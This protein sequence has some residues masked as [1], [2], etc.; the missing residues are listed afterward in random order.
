LELAVH[1]R[2]FTQREMTMCGSHPSL[3]SLLEYMCG[4]FGKDEK[5]L[6]DCS[7]LRWKSSTPPLL[8]AGLPSGNAYSS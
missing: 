8:V 6:S 4:F 1:F 5:G 7:F 2:T 3:N